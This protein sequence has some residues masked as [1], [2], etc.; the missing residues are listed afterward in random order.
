MFLVALWFVW[1]NWADALPS[2]PRLE[3]AVIDQ[4]SEGQIEA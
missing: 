2:L 1:V 4:I 3:V